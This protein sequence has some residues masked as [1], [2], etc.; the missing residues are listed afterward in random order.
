MRRS[1]ATR[2]RGRLRRAQSPA[3]P[4]TAAELAQLAGLVA[5]Y[6]A[7]APTPLDP[8]EIAA[9]PFEMARVPL[10]PVA[11]AGYVASAG[12]GSGAIAQTRAVARQ[13]PRSSWLVTNAARLHDALLK[14]HATEN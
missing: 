4:P 12:D 5:D 9:L 7:T 8:A 3:E 10:Y 13:L 11:E 14:R 6:E 2:P 1:D